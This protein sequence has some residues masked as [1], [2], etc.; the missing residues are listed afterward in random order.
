MFSEKMLERPVICIN[1]LKVHI[2]VSTTGRSPQKGESHM[3][4]N[5]SMRENAWVPR[6]GAESGFSLRT[7]VQKSREQ[8]LKTALGGADA[9]PNR[10]P[11]QLKP[12]GEIRIGGVSNSTI[13]GGPN[14][15]NFTLFACKLRP[16]VM[17][18]SRRPGR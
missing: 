10:L 8:G 12:A 6:R 9:T 13:G 16:G 14:V 3:H 18:Y 1:T 11:R 15:R 7:V 2:P 4:A 5:S 17:Q